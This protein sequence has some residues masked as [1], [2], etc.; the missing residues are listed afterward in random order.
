VG[1]LIFCSSLKWFEFPW[2]WTLA[3]LQLINFAI[4]LSQATI[5]WM[6]MWAMFVFIFL[7]G[8]VSGLT[9]LNNYNC[10]LNDPRLSEVE[11]ELGSNFAC[12]SPSLSSSRRCSRG[13]ASTLT[14]SH[15]SRDDERASKRYQ[16]AGVCFLCSRVDQET[17]DHRCDELHSNLCES[18]FSDR[19]YIEYASHHLIR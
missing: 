17:T 13:S 16:F 12:Q 18:L 6:P 14:S 4:W 11:R 5:H 19:S 9:Y 1:I 10:V 3:A 8:T 2:L 15:L 7:V